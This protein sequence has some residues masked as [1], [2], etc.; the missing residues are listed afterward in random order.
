M[1]T[2]APP[3]AS[4]PCATASWDAAEPLAATAPFAPTW[5]LIEQPGPWGA[6]ALT[7]SRLDAA[8]GREL[9][10]AGSAA[11]VRPALIRR[12][13]RHAD[14]GAPGRTRIFLA[15]TVPGRSWVRTALL[16]HPGQLRGLDLARLGRGEH[17]GTGTAYRGAP[18]ALV[19]TN[20]RRDVCCAQLGRPLTAELAADAGA[21]VWEITHIGGHRFAPTLLVLP[22]GYAYGRMSGH[23]VKQVLA[24]LRGDRIVTD[25]CR[26]RTCWDR[27]GQAAELAVRALT[28]SAGADA[29]TV[30]DVT[31][32]PDGE[33][34]DRWR[35]LVG[36]ADGRR[37]RVRVAERTTDAPLAA[38]CGAAPLPQSRPEAVAVAEV[39]GPGGAAA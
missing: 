2:S 4:A 18:L 3:D 22:H 6:K 25:G 15:H 5:L 12:P 28:G 36:H 7:Q 38:S 14:P 32:V 39:T 35:A 16:D 11:G 9:E 20:G 10:R 21:S 23:A 27:P 13:G 33:A 37:W 31:A 17:D 30:L 26:G 29:L 24:E 34:A 1:S 8:L 19:C